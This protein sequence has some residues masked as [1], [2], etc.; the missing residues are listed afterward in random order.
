MGFVPGEPFCSVRLKANRT[1]TVVKV[2]APAKH[3]VQQVSIGQSI[4]GGSGGVEQSD[5]SASRLSFR[6]S[7][8]CEGMVPAKRLEF[9]F[10]VLRSLRPN[11]LVGIAPSSIFFSKSIM[12]IFVEV[13]LTAGKLPSKSLFAR[14]RSRSCGSWV[15]LRGTLSIKLLSSVSCFWHALEKE[16]MMRFA[17]EEIKIA[18]TLFMQSE[19]LTQINFCDH[20]IA[21]ALASEPITLARIAEVRLL[22]SLAS[23][24]FVAP[25]TLIPS[26]AISRIENHCKNIPLL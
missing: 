24:V 2:Q 5:H 15:T 11:M 8:I 20:S 23:T 21:I 16:T 13:K 25:E 18:H 4:K 17:A 3:C 22:T 7:Q 9:N 1:K 10:K 6:R 26:H 12:L 14:M 19:P